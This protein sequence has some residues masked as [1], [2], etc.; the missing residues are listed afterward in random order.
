[1]GGILGFNILAGAADMTAHQQLGHF[2]IAG[3]N[4]FDNSA[5]FIERFL[6]T[7][8]HGTELVTVHTHQ[9]I[10]LANQH[11]AKGSVMAALNDAVVKVQIPFALKIGGVFAQILLLFM[12]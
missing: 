1:M 12:L 4:G 8:G 11:L 6:R 7:I 10:Q 2:A 5:V 9:V 3:F